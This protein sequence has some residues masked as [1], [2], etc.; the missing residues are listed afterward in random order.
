[1]GDWGSETPDPQRANLPIL[2]LTA[3]PT[4]PS[5]DRVFAAGADDFVTKPVVDDI[6][7]KR[8]LNRL[9][10]SGLN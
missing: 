6:L 3:D 7:V 10:K 5:I 9:Q 2:F 8:V 1:V 4:A